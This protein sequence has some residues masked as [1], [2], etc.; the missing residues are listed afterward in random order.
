[1]GNTTTYVDL[2]TTSDDDAFTIHGCGQF[3]HEGKVLTK[4]EALLLY[5]ELHKWLTQ[6]K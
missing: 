6:S 2:M 1:M 4:A 5:V 3:D